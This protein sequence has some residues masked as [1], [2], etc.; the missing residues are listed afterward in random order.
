MIDRSMVRIRH[1]GEYWANQAWRVQPSPKWGFLQL[2]PV[3]VWR[4][5]RQSRCVRC[6]GIVGNAVRADYRLLARPEFLQ[7][8]SK[9]MICVS[10]TIISLEGRSDQMASNLRISVSNCRRDASRV[11]RLRQIARGSRTL[12]TAWQPKKGKLNVRR[13][14]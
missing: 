13:W 11:S 6:I 3:R 9:C 1:C 12:F 8:K 10:F 14:R 7:C 5:I 4:L 2:R